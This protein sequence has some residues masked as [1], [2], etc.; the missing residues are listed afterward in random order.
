MKKLNNNQQHND[1]LQPHNLGS[2]EV[3]ILTPYYSSVKLQEY[4]KLQHNNEVKKG[5]EILHQSSYLGQSSMSSMEVHGITTQG[6]LKAEVCIPKS[7]TPFIATNENQLN[8]INEP[9]RN[10]VWYPKN[11]HKLWIT[12]GMIWVIVG[13]K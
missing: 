1:M 13:Y 10:Q 12:L 3:P 9:H 6:N 5:Q 2:Q 4:W 11:T 7:T 8:I